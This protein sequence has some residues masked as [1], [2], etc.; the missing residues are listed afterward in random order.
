MD[1][2]RV[3][4]IDKNDEVIPL[5]P[6]VDEF[7]ETEFIGDISPNAKNS[8][9]KDSNNQEEKEKTLLDSEH[10]K[11]TVESASKASTP[12]SAKKERLP[13]LSKLSSPRGNVDEIQQV[14]TDDGKSMD[15]KQQ[16]LEEP[17]SSR[18]Q[19]VG[20]WSIDSGR[21]L[22]SQSDSRSYRE[23][24]RD[25]F[26]NKDRP[27]GG[28]SVASSQSSFWQRRLKQKS[29]VVSKYDDFFRKEEEEISAALE[30]HQ[31]MRVKWQ[32][33]DHLS[34]EAEESYN[35]FTK[36][37]DEETEEIKEEKQKMSP[38]AGDDVETEEQT[39]LLASD[40]LGLPHESSSVLDPYVLPQV[41]DST[42]QLQM[43]DE[44]YFYPTNDPVPLEDKIDGD[45]PIRRLEEEGLFVGDPPQIPLSWQN[46]ERSFHTCDVT[47][48][49]CGEE[50]SYRLGG[51]CRIVPYDDV[52][53]TERAS[54]M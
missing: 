25:R 11:V 51:M 27:G 39:R 2:D 53:R 21:S 9:W 19:S 49:K 26:Q 22:T 37:W 16:H 18:R 50:K 44:I 47:S 15:K 32:K 52:L 38:P 45:V 31:E 34:S 40:F 33:M 24:L 48:W 10:G 23:R 42:M 20:D 4:L 12:A 13:P 7:D 8:A 41:E 36:V 43:E 29:P 6:T 54:F 1:K 46:R 5:S 30:K 3:E 28:T 17:K 35:F 14:G